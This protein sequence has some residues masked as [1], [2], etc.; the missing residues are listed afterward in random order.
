MG[1]EITDSQLIESALVI[2]S[3]RAIAFSGFG[4]AGLDISS[5]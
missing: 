5:D 4:V 2:G 1:S 3:Q